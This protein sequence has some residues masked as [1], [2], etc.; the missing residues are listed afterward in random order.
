MKQ[1]VNNDDVNY[2]ISPHPSSEQLPDL[3]LLSS[4]NPIQTPLYSNA[5]PHG[6]SS[7]TRLR[8]PIYSRNNHNF[9]SAPPGLRHPPQLRLAVHSLLPVLPG[10]PQRHSPRISKPPQPRTR[11]PVLLPEL[12]LISLSPRR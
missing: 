6:S 2:P 10:N 5:I 11:S 1:A 12:L 3:Q 4:T 7:S 9:N 8:A